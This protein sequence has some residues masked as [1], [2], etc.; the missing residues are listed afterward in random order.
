MSCF[1]V[2]YGCAAF[3]ADV[4]YELRIGGTYS[5]NV[6]RTE[7][8]KESE[9][10]AQAGFS[11]D[12]N[13][14]S[15]LTEFAL[16]SDIDFNH[17]TDGSY[18][19]E[20]VGALNADFALDLVQNFV[21]WVATNRFGTLQ[22]NP[23]VSDSVNNRGNFNRFS[24]GPEI[25]VP[26][27]SRTS[28]G[29]GAQYSDTYYEERDSDN[30]VLSGQISISRAISSRRTLAIAATYE[31]VSF[32]DTTSNTDYERASAYLSFQSEISKGS[33]S[34]SL[35]MN[36][37]DIAG[38][39]LDGTLA[40]LSFSRDLTGRTS[41]DISYDQQYSNSG[42][43]FSLTQ[44]TP[45]RDFG[46]TQDVPGDGEP[47]ESRRLSAALSS[48]YGSNE[49]YVRASSDEESYDSSNSLDRQRY[50]ISAG[51]S[52][53]LGSN[54]RISADG[55]FSQSDYENVDREDDDTDI[56]LGISRQLT[57][58]LSLDLDYRYSDRSSDNAG[59]SDTE[60]RYTLRLR[61][62]P[63]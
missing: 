25:T 28:L 54:W 9:L 11:I 30:D 50:T 53:R 49:L 5:D 8:S 58:T 12:L 26:L 1:A 41:F 35:G 3:S 32:D 44:G 59:A 20:V 18:D 19:D 6:G 4:D 2:L 7:S 37:I 46:G 14:E 47:F 13:Q 27:G 23:F 33:I 57:R 21:Q 31:D 15:R 17:Y 34:A 39:T 56:R 55:R 22:T 63:E 60:N 51:V 10:I 61:F 52:R 42:D 24:T 62:D 45:G 38:E 48:E 43:I 36:E 40:Q 16:L 29:L